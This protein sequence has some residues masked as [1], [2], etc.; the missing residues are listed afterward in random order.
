VLCLNSRTGW[1]ADCVSKADS[2]SLETILFHSGMKFHPFQKT[3]FSFSNHILPK[4]ES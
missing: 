4:K 1:S 2:S 3:A